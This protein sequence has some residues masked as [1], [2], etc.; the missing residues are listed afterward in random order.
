MRLGITGHRGLTEDVEHVV[1]TAL[2]TV[3]RE[4]AGDDLVGVSCLADGPDAWFAQE[5]LRNGG[6]IEAVLPAE[7]YRESLPGSHHPLYDDL[8]RRSSQVHTTGLIQPG[9]EAYQIGNEIM[10]GLVDILVAVWDGRPA[11]GYGGT[12]DAVSY[13]HRTGLPVRVIW[14]QGAARDATSAGRP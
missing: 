12:A 1:R 8:V 4:Y 3:V 6:R 5:I 7:E 11:R 13:A 14:P 2:G 9:P 10:M